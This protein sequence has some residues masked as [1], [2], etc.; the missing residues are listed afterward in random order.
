M[1]GDMFPF[2][3]RFA[4]R[5]V[6]RY[7]I[8][9]WCMEIVR[10]R[11][12]SEGYWQ[13]SRLFAPG[14]HANADQDHQ[15]PEVVSGRLRSYFDS[16]L[17]GNGI[18]KWNHYF[19]MYERHFAK[20]VD[21]DVRICEIGVYSGGSLEMWRHYFGAG[22]SIY[23]VDIEPACRN[24]ETEYVKIIVGDQADR[25]FWKKFRD[26]VPPLDIV[27]DD[28][29]HTVQQQIVTLEETLPYLNPGGVYI[30]EDIHSVANGFAH[31]VSGLLLNLNAAKDFKCHEDHDRAIT[32]TA[33]SFQSAIR[34][35]TLYPFAVVIERNDTPISELTSSKRGT[36]WQP[37]F[38][39]SHDK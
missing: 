18:Y 26:G 21:R 33:S 12:S 36:N 15:F 13:G 5:A 28:G 30:C 22:C 24:Y 8:V 11:T 37:F 29:G 17:E 1:I 35:V 27:I 31:Y 20:F 25:T 16:H 39:A 10:S 32:V 2:L 14:Q 9:S 38:D 7:R 23:G 4:Q 19:E 34:S 6:L 3:Q